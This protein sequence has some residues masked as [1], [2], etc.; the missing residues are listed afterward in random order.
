MA[1]YKRDIVDI[2]LETGNIHR[3]FLKHSI[4][5]LDQQADR[6][7]I[8]T[9]RDGAPVD[10]SGVSV[11]GIFM[12]PQG[13]PISITGVQYTSV[14][15][16]EA[17][18][19]LPQACYNY[20][21]QFTLAIKLVDST[22]AITGTMRIIDGMVDNTHASG[23]VAPTSAVPTYQ[24]ILATYD[25]MV[26]ATAATNASLANYYSDLPSRIPAGTYCIYNH[27]LYRCIATIATKGEW[28]SSY[29]TPVK[30][31]NDVHDL[32]SDVNDSFAGY[33]SDLPSS[34]PVGT[35]CI[36]NN[37]LYRCISPIESKGAWDATKWAEAKL[38]NDTSDLKSAIEFDQVN[39]YGAN[40]FSVTVDNASKVING[41]TQN[42]G[43]WGGITGA[44]EGK[45]KSALLY[46]SELDTITITA[47]SAAA[48]FAFL[49]SI[50]VNPTDNDPVDYCAGTGQNSVNAGAT[51]IYSIPN[52]CV[53]IAIRYLLNRVDQYP[54]SVLVTGASLRNT[55]KTVEQL[56]RELPFIKDN[57][58]SQAEEKS[59]TW[60]ADYNGKY[61]DAEGNVQTNANYHVSNLI[62]MK[63]GY[64]RFSYTYT[65]TATTRIHG[66]DEN[67]NWIRQLAT[68]SGGT[69]TIVVQ[70]EIASDIKKIRISCSSGLTVSSLAN[71]IALKVDA[72][73]YKTSESTNC[74]EYR[75]TGIY[76]V[77][78]TF[79]NL[80]T[81]VVNNGMIVVF[82]ASA[83]RVFQMFAEYGG[84]V[85][86][87]RVSDSLSTFG[88]WFKMG[89]T[90]GS[91]ADQIAYTYT[92]STKTLILTCGLTRYTIKRSTDQSINLDSWRLTK[93]EIQINGS[94][95]TM[96]DGSDAE[97]PVKIDNEADFISGF[98]GDEVLDTAT[99]YI[100]N[101]AL[102]T[103][104]DSSGVCGSAM[105]YQKS[106]VYRC[107]SNTEA[108]T[109]YKRVRFVGN[110]FNV[111]QRWIAKV[112]C[113]VTRG[114]LCLMQCLNT[115]M[116]GWDTD[117]LLPM[118]AVDYAE[119]VV[120]DTATRI[121]NY[122]LQDN[123]K[124]SLIAEVGADAPGYA[125]AANYIPSQNRSKYY[126][127]MYNGKQL[128]VGDE[129]VSKFSVT[130][131]D[132]K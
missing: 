125:P 105:L 74:N 23:T 37:I 19:V 128:S 89:N 100:D 80:P 64:G 18:V 130:F 33:Y 110:D 22:N 120:L 61:I 11:Q 93:G 76:N 2:N 84:I 29:W 119:N 40:N 115:Y 16:N 31:G 104:A 82:R 53:C 15:G 86:W 131:N 99:I 25:A 60:D 97:G 69:G 124:M 30:L 73:A 88:E 126:F 112:N 102:N 36:Y 54:V 116:I 81:G 28:D 71:D 114:A 109:R 56:S 35:Y 67:G 44:N 9:Y 10:L 45:Y 14:I 55:I 3:S 27:V 92:S 51:A 38:A 94:Y 32:R 62:S 50:P 39:A 26:A 4:G 103:S 118:N 85:L 63:Y 57:V 122:Y 58:I 6:F 87:G 107:E 95:K 78:A 91:A 129:L 1:I 21:G 106:T 41:I 79:S 43:T 52:D 101:S 17:I 34:I 90:G 123:I 121:G 46:V 111:Q 12:P 127:D 96:W 77:S 59:V 49:K 7:G 68:G 66:Y 72:L 5:Y 8:R 108:F 113:T 42:A 117:L 13:S 47:G 132:L 24:E 75:E 48:T 83:Y 65:G 70:F 98:H 20:D